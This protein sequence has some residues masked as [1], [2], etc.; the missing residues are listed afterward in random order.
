MEKVARGRKSH[1]ATSCRVPELYSFPSFRSHLLQDGFGACPRW[2]IPFRFLSYL[3]PISP[4]DLLCIILKLNGFL[5][6]TSVRKSSRISHKFVS[7]APPRSAVVCKQ[8]CQ[9]FNL[10]SILY[11]C[12]LP[13]HSPLV[14]PCLKICYRPIHSQF[15]ECLKI[16]QN[17]D[18]ASPGQLENIEIKVV[19]CSIVVKFYA[20][21]VC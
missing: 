4:L 1:L 12:C 2:E 17:Q 21:V 11:L 5:T 18:P 16:Y 19:H 13:I 9:V 7:S 20:F 3:K 10:I 14:E 8:S 15:Q 6:S